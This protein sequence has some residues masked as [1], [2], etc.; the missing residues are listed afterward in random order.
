MTKEQY[1]TFENYQFLTSGDKD[2]QRELN[3]KNGYG[4]SSNQ[5]LRLIRE[6]KQA[7]AKEDYYTMTLIEFRLTH[8]NFHSECGLLNKGEYKEARKGWS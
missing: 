6:H 7:R 3:S 2:H 8:I 4:L 1:E 5:M